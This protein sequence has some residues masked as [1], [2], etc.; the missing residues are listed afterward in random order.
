MANLSFLMAAFIIIWIVLFGYVLL[1]AQRQKR[2]QKE[3]DT[4]KNALPEQQKPS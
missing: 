2:L 1:L 3:V 4:L